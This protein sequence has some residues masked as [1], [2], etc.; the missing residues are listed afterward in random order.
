MKRD[1]D[2]FL[3]A[4]EEDADLAWRLAE[5]AARPAP[6]GLRERIVARHRRRRLFG[7]P[8][9]LPAALAFAL[10]ALV[11]L[12]LSL[13]A[14]QTRAELERAQVQRDEYVQVLAAVAAGGQILP[15]KAS[16]G[17]SGRGTLV[18]ARDGQA[19]LIIELPEPPAGKAYEAWVIRGGA[20]LRAGMAPAR[21]GVVTL[22]LD[23]PLRPGDIAAVT[24][25]NAAGVDRPTADPLLVGPS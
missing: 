2:L 16:A 13:V 18:V 15:M 14:M 17:T 11:V 23:H 6:A 25:E 4:L 22:R 1:D 24:L 7:L 12:P 21:S 20:P 3:E 10:V 9:P 5:A 19:Y 8:A